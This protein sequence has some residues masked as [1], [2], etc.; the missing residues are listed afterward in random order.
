M[1]MKL[2]HV[3]CQ[4]VLRG[5]QQRAEYAQLC[6][7]KKMPV[8]LQPWHTVDG[9]VPHCNF[10]SWASYQDASRK[11]SLTTDHSYEEG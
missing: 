8:T 7:Y 4:H 2:I 9:S 10:E 1:D 3:N 5:S 6:K 11:H